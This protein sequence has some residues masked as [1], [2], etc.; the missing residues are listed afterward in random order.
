MDAAPGAGGLL[1]VSHLPQ[2]DWGPPILAEGRQPFIRLPAPPEREREP[3]PTAEGNGEARASAGQG[4]TEETWWGCSGHRAPTSALAPPTPGTPQPPAQLPGPPGGLLLEQFEAGEP[5]ELLQQHGGGGSEQQQRRV[6][7][8][9]ELHRHEPE[10]RGREQRQQ[11]EKRPGGKR[12][13]RLALRASASG[14][15]ARYSRAGSLQLPQCCPLTPGLPQP[16]PAPPSVPKGP[17][18]S[19]EHP[20]QWPPGL[21]TGP[22]SP[23]LGPLRLTPPPAR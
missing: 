20:P 15:A 9:A 10:Q 17:P 11:P 16:P 14:R 21:P 8:P 1:T 12:D 19:S 3:H 5:A 7:P 13:S 2:G 4:E 22:L 6:L 23:A 18:G